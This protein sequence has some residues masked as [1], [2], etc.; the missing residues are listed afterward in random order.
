M[1]A[2]GNE[3]I[4]M[5]KDSALVSVISVQET[6]WSRSASAGPQLEPMTALLIAASVYWMLTIAF[7]FV[8]ARLER[9]LAES[10]R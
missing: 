3:F 10:D 1:P 9:R 7:T 4:A 2:I 5:M 8:Q 6:L